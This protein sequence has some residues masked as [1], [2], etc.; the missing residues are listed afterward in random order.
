MKDDKTKLYEVDLYKPIKKYFTEQGFD[1]YGE[2]NDCDVVAMKD[3]ELIIVELKLRFNLDLVMQ[4][5]KRQR[6]T[7]QVYIA[8]PKPT[9][10]FRSQRWRDLCYLTRRLEVGLLIVSFMK[11]NAQVELIHYPTPFDR[12]KS[13]QL[14]KKRKSKLLKEIK[15]RTGDF[16]V[17]GSTNMKIM[18]AYKENCIHI[19]CCLLHY[20]ALSPKE[21]RQLGTGDRTP[22]ILSENHYGWFERVRRG[23]YTI[24]EVGR[25]ELKEY[26]N[27][28]KHY[29]SLVIEAENETKK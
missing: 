6:M 29:E 17:G 8:I 19:A 4:A 26:P 22:R 14:S 1:V 25:N 9:Y 18:S 23:V 12:I 16:N 11:D 3:E 15:G 24:S 10:S 7:D 2:V 21:V 13:M 27:F 20:G 5:T 28:V